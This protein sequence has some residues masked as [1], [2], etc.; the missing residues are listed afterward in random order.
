VRVRHAMPLVMKRSIW[1]RRRRC[2]GRIAAR[3]LADAIDDELRTV[4]RSRTAVMARDAVPSA[5]IRSVARRPRTC[6][7]ASSTS[8]W[9]ARP[10]RRSPAVASRPGSRVRRPSGTRPSSAASGTLLSGGVTE[11]GRRVSD[12]TPRLRWGR[13]G[14]S[15][16]RYAPDS[17]LASA[18]RARAW[19]TSPRRVADG[20]RAQACSASSPSWSGS[21]PSVT[22][23][24]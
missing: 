13:G 9:P 7:T 1:P 12:P 15:T 18:S 24:A 6:Q 17:P 14:A 20:D 5:A 4:S 2:Q 21:R 19:R 11:R 8:R 23:R 22:T 16:S 3:Q 10:G